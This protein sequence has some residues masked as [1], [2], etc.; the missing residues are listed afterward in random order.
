MNNLIGYLILT[1]LALSLAAVAFYEPQIISNH[2]SFLCGFVD[3]DLLGVLG[4]IVAITAASASSVHLELRRLEAEYKFRNGFEN[5]RKEVKRGA[6]A[7]LLLF[8]VAFAL[9]ILKP[10]ISTNERIEAL[11]N[12]AAIVIV[13]WNVLVLIALLQLAFKVGPIDLGEE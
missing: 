2:N 7:L 3:Q 8:L 12:G 13:V 10:I 5:T 9:V 1:V 6:F 11:V 4:F